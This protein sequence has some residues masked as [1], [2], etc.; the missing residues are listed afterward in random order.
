MT[1]WDC[2]SVNTA[3]EDDPLKFADSFSFASRAISP[4]LTS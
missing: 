2:D 4:P 3:R 1:E